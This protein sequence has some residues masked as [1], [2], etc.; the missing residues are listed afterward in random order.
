MLS[1]IQGLAVITL[2][3][4]KL[5]LLYK[6]MIMTIIGARSMVSV[7]LCVTEVDVGV[8]LRICGSCAKSSRVFK[9]I[10][11]VRDRKKSNC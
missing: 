6:I 2:A 4:N 11:L 8:P 9:F 1:T 3:H 10:Q 7:C 5:L